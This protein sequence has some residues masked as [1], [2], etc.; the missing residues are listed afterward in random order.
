M[1][2]LDTIASSPGRAYDYIYSNYGLSGLIVAGVMV[3]VAIVGV[4]IA[5]DR[6]K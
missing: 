5:L 1:D 4:F 2:S 6:R 3:V